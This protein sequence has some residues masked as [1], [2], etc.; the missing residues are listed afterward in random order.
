MARA[1][2]PK[3]KIIELYKL[4][5]LM[6]QLE[7]EIESEYHKDEMKTP[8]HLCVGQEAI[9]AAVAANLRK[10]DRVFSN[11]RGHGHYAARGGDLKKM[12]AELYGRQTG[13]SC[14]RG[15]S[16]HLVD[17][18][19]GLMGSTS[20][21]AGGIPIA[22]GAALSFSMKK[23]KQ[24]SVVF[25]GDA[26]TEEG[27]F[28]ESVNFAVL[29]NLP[30]L[31]VCE[32][33]FYSVCSHQSGRQAKDNI[34]KK[35]KNCGIKGF[36]VDGTDVLGTYVIARR[37]IDGVRA[38]RGPCLIEA[39]A[40]RWRGHVGAG[41]DTALGYRSKEELDAWMKRC[42]VDGLTRFIL[43]QGIA[44]R[45]ELAVMD[46]DIRYR[47]DEAFEFA[48]NGPFPKKEEITR[49]LFH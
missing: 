2:I 32:N 1:G 4:V 15:G 28:Y 9:A 17:T 12:I 13:C 42:P 47:I 34:Y 43:R 19:V 49:Y 11:H 46:N 25:F 38:G 30:V 3:N 24:I 6:R 21:V 29:K 44:T 26:A 27:V 31:F 23:T 20:I 22:V 10:N 16:M 8:I 48:K 41:P 36:R 40:Y 5:R 37:C 35:L 18:S 14:G 39:R 45:T 7:L 33:N